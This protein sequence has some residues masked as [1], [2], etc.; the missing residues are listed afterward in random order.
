MAKAKKNGMLNCLK[1][2]TVKVLFL[3]RER[4]F[5]ATFAV[6]FRAVNLI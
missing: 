2:H 6:P 3:A 4:K 5:I 1:C